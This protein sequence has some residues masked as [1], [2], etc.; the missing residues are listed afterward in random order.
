MKKCLLFLTLFLILAT[1]QSQTKRVLFLGNSYTYVN[2][3][4]QM[5][6]YMASSAGDTLLFESNAMG[7][8]TFYVHSINTVSISKIMSGHWD[9]VV[10]QG[11]SLEMWGTFPDILASFPQ[12][13][14]LDSLIHQYNQCAETVFFRTWGRKNGFP[15]YSFQTMDSMIHVSYMKLAGSLN[16][17]VSPVGEVWKYI[18]QHNPSIE[19]YDPDESHPSLAGT[20]AAACCFYTALYRKS[21]TL[22]SYNPGLTTSDAAEIRNAAKLVVYDSLLN[23]HIGE[24]DSLIHIACNSGTLGQSIYNDPSI[25]IFPNPFSSQAT[26]SVNV[27]FHNASLTMDNC[28]GQTVKQ[29]NHISGQA[30]I[31]DRGHLPGGLYFLRLT[32][33]NKIFSY[34]IIIADN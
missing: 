32:E 16:A 3:L 14:V 9:Y 11:Q 26:L 21:P 29:L 19:L 23:W 6:A 13:G 34:K 27:P 22:I 12:V 7:G 5:I 24:Y 2:N 20:Y 30:V 15:P 4:P 31:L 1:A 8:A 10:L 17:V 18:R 25:K 33:G 28:F